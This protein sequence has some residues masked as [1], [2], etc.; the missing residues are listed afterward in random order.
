MDGE[1]YFAWDR[2]EYSLGKRFLDREA[3]IGAWVLK[4]T[5][6]MT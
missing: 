3:L 6:V 5:Q 1:T 2:R 4:T